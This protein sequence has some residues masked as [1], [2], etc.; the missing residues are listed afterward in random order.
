MKPQVRAEVNWV[1]APPLTMTMDGGL[2]KY[3]EGAIVGKRL[4]TSIVRIEI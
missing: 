4:P 2:T 3:F 1:V